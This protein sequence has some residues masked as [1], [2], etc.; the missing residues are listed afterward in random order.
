[1]STYLIAFTISQLNHTGK[2]GLHQIFARPQ[3][4]TEGKAN[5]ALERSSELLRSVEDYF[6]M[7]YTFS[8]ITHVAVPDEY[9][10]IEA[11]ENWGHITYK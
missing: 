2:N 1:M 11:L 5:Y 10:Q 7:K 8:K 6:D 3:V 4:I 9:L